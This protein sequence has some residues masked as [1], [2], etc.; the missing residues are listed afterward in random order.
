VSKI[1]S[2][3]WLTVREVA[4][5]NLVTCQS[6]YNLITKERLKAVKKNGQWRI[7]PKDIE[8]FS[9]YKYSHENRVVDGKK[10]FDKENGLYSIP[11]AAKAFGFKIQRL[12]YLQRM[13]I[14]PAQRIGA[15]WVVKEED[16]KKLRKRGSI[17]CIS[18]SK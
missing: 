4:K 18:Q 9:K 2:K 7:N 13:G 8:E 12:Y 11:E 10:V 17:S 16:V 3:G 6:V 5:M 15:A 14:L 1:A